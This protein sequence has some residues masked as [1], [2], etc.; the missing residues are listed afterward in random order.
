MRIV[1]FV[2]S[3]VEA[4]EKEVSWLYNDCYLYITLQVMLYYIINMPF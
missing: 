2:G 3:P 1:V 4:D